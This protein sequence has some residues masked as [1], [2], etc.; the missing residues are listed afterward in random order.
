MMRHLA[1]AA[2]AFLLGMQFCASAETIAAGSQIQVKVNQPIE[3]HSWER[4]RI[5]PARV[6]QD[7]Y[8]QDWDIA[9][10]RGSEAELV[11]RRT[12]PGQITVDLEAVTVNG[13]RYVVDAGD[14]Q[15]STA[16]G[17]A[18]LTDAA[19]TFQL[20]EAVRAYV[21]TEPGA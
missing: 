7:V 20:Q 19:I 1:L 8:N 13:Q 10:P 15:Y 4:E 2:T 21:L 14:L 9:I 17:Y 12:D 16:S 5:Y 18:P 11:V 3:L 6:A